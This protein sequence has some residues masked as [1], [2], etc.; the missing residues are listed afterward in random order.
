MT[1]RELRWEKGKQIIKLK[2]ELHR[3][4]YMAIKFAEGE[5]TAEEYA[6]VKEQRKAWRAEINRLQAEIEV[7]MA[8]EHY[9]TTQNS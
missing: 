3:T 9:Y 4:D 8:E 1:N 7:L 5:L 2:G 6:E